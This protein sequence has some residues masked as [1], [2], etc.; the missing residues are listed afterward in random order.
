MAYLERAKEFNASPPHGAPYSLPVPDS[1]QA[2]R[3]AIYR[4]WR[5]KDG[6][7]KSLD[8]NVS[9]RVC[10]RMMALVPG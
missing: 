4:H 1:E 8:P 10:N 7:L 5:F 2:G 6:I 9:P 3:S